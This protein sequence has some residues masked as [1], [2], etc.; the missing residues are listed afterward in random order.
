MN[1]NL[2]SPHLLLQNYPRTVPQA[3]MEALRQRFE[4]QFSTGSS[5]SHVLGEF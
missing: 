4:T 3:L 2:A 1:A 5:T